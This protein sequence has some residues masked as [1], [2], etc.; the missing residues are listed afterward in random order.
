MI[1]IEYF[2]CRK[3]NHTHELECMNKIGWSATYQFTYCNCGCSKPIFGNL[4][5][6]EYKYEQSK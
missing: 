1:V 5:Y 3:C 4:E 6:L 2:K